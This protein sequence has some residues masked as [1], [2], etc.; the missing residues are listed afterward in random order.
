[1]VGRVLTSN[2]I[3]S[4]AG[5]VYSL[6]GAVDLSEQER[7]ALLQLCQEQLDAFRRVLQNYGHREE[8][9]LF[10]ELQTSKRVL[11]RNELAF[12]IADAYPVTEGHS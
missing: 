7:H 12:C 8:G 1:M 3:T 4:H 5:G 2:G 11:L 6:I 9:C 10:C